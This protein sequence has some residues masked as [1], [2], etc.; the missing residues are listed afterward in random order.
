MAEFCSSERRLRLIS[1]VTHRFGRPQMAQDCVV[2]PAVARFANQSVLFGSISR[3]FQVDLVL[4]TTRFFRL[5]I[6]LAD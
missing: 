1:G 6:P 2:A 3:S 5:M 4:V